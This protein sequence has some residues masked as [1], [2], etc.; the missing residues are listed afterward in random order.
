VKSNLKQSLRSR[1]LNLSA[2]GDVGIE[3][4]KF[5]F[6]FGCASGSAR[7]A[8]R[9][10]EEPNVMISHATANNTPFETI[11]RLFID[12]GGYSQ[13][14]YKQGYQ[15]S[16]QDYLDY[17]AEYSPERYVLRDYPCE[18][19][20]LWKLG[21]TVDE[22]QR[23]TTQ[24]HRQLLEDHENQG[25]SAEPVAVLQGWTPKQYIAH[26]DDLRDA[27]ALTRYVAIGTLCRR[28][29][30]S[31]VAR[32]V[33]TVRETLP[34]S[35]QLHAFGLKTSVLQVPG[36]VDALDSADSTAYD[37]RTRMQ[38]DQSTWKEQVYHYLS[39]KREIETAVTQSG[40][41]DSLLQYID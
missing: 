12:S 38:E 1:R 27:G 31:T 34:G 39:M 6:Y 5:R 21:R 3:S 17:V 40:E 20:L 15:S 30:I 28:H 11:D 8:L 23:R 26:L 16:D 14:H 33:R 32:I 37:F 35:Y 25:I 4:E 36:I 19:D 22:H 18:P 2:T 29:D 9:K 7:K 24:H 41:Q 10:M 13:L